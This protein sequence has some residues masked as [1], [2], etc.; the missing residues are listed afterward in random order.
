MSALSQLLEHA[1]I[2]LGAQLYALRTMRQQLGA[3]Y[4]EEYQDGYSEDGYNQ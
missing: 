2:G 3:G 4:Q 1:D